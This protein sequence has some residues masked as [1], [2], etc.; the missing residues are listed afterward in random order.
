MSKD[1]IVEEK[2]AFDEEKDKL[3][4]IGRA[5]GL[6]DERMDE[7]LDGALEDVNRGDRDWRAAI[8]SVRRF[9]MTQ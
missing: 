6:S 7:L 4:L 1:Y 8:V 9:I 3:F 2:L 5:K